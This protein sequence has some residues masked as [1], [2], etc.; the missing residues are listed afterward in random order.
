MKKISPWHTVRGRLLLLALGVE[1]AML[2]VL[3]FNSMRLLQEAM[4]SQ[5]QWQAEQMAPVLNAA[6]TAPLAQQ[7]FATMQA[8]LDESRATEGIDYIAVVS[9]SGNIV[10]ASG[11]PLDKPLHGPSKSFSLFDSSSTPRYDVV[12]PITQKGQRLGA[13]HFGLDLSK[14]ISAR[15]SLLVQGISIAGVELLLSFIIMLSIGY[16]LTRHLTLLT[17][18]SLQVAAGNLPPPTVYEGKD[19]IGQLGAAFNTMSRVIAERVRE[20]TNAKEAAEEVIRERDSQK[21]LL[22]ATID[23]TPDLVFFKD[24]D[25]VYLGCNQAFADFVG[26]TLQEI[27]GC[28]DYDLFSLET[29]DF[30]REQDRKMLARGESRSNEEW[31]QYPDGRSA[32]LDTKKSPLR[33]TDGQLIGMIGVARDI[34]ARKQAEEALRESEARLK[35]IMESVQTGI[36]IIDSETHTI[37]DVNQNTIKMIG[38]PKEMIIGSICHSY[39]CPAEKGKCPVM[40]LAHEIDNSERVLLRSDGVGIPILKTVV[41]ITLGGRKHL[42][43]SFIDITH[44][45]QAEEE[46]Q[47]AKEKTE[48]AS[49]AKDDLISNVSH[50]LRT[51]L[52]SIIGFTSTI[53]DDK[54]LSDE[55]REEFLEIVLVESRRLSNLIEDLLDVSR[56]ES[57]KIDLHVDTHEVGQLLE[58]LR[59]IFHGQFDEKG[60]NLIITSPKEDICIPCDESRINQ[61]LQNLLSNALK[62]TPAGGSVCVNVENVSTKDVEIT[63]KDTGIGIPEDDIPFIFEKF[64]RVRHHGTLF[65]GTGLGL[66]I[67]KTIIDQHGGSIRVESAEGEGSV[68]YVTLPGILPV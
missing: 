2:T 19:D 3:V 62:F 16:W 4:I 5:A 65:S 45:K 31:V 1:L 58:G 47:S 29:A 44:R 26:R 54:E 68:F 53:R 24:L 55:M 32:L 48:R 43:E 8:V 23:S 11:W 13:L 28:A 30:F 21:A 51:P 49:R 39:I 67:T 17:Q 15:R 50:E 41:P 40:D 22:M 9:Q 27:K 35:N 18:A 25:G 59:R 14:I 46:L 66:T 6:L 64:Y 52:A 7:D 12:V 10:A 20:L 42:L 37:V 36:M 34:T 57:G 60:V 63:I 61:V 38:D 33:Y 56:I